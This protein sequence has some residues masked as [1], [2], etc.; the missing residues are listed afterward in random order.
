M[1]AEDTR[2]RIKVL[3]K[4]LS[5]LDLFD[6]KGKELTATEIGRRLGLNKT[7]TF[8]ILAV[9]EEHNFLEKAPGSLRYRLGTKIF[10]LGSFVESS[11][12]IRKLARPPLEELKQLCDETIHLV[13]LE[14]GEALYLDKI[15]GKKAIRVVSRVG[16]KLPAH[17]SGVGKVL[18]ASLPQEEVD[19]I[20]GERGLKR[21]TKN[22]IT[23]RETLRKE[24]SRIRR[25]GYALDNEEVEEGLKCVAA[26][27][28][29]LNGEVIAAISVSGPRNRFSEMETSRL[30]PLVQHTADRV[31]ETLKERRLTAE[32][33]RSSYA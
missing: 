15:E 19:R 33:V 11:A 9:L 1:A 14:H 29:D 17:C 26:P 27:V 22:T 2:Y 18:L 32:L 13:V 21:F 16:Q 24:L 20:I 12:E 4:A 8:R 10:L 23:D 28:K 31:S 25:Q 3:E 6:E 30:I 7:T 5:I